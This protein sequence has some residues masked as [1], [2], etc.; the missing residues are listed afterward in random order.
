MVIKRHPLSRIALL[1]AKHRALRQRKYQPM[2]RMT[3]RISTSIWQTPTMHSFTHPLS[4]INKE[5]NEVEERSEKKNMNWVQAKRAFPKL[6]PFG[7]VDKDGIYNMFD[8]KPFDRKRQGEEHKHI[9]AQWLIDEAEADADYEKRR[10]K[11]EQEWI[12]KG[13]PTSEHD[14]EEELDRAEGRAESRRIEEHESSDQLAWNSGEGSKTADKN[15]TKI[16]KKY[17]NIPF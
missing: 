14:Y 17:K 15:I 12:R 11:A 8:C 6:A 4:P 3:P 16:A 7:D 13:S 5:Y 1:R 10:A 9:S 2:Q